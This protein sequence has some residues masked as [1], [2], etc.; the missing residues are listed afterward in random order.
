MEK[1]IVLC[2]VSHSGKTTYAN[3]INKKNKYVIINSDEIRIKL[4]GDRTIK[5]DENK[6]W[7]I[8]EK[9]KNNAIKNHKNIILDAC[10]LSSQARWHAK[11]NING[12][13]VE[14]VVLNP[15]LKELKS[16]WEKENRR[17]D[18]EIIKD[19]YNNFTVSKNKLRLEGYEN[20]KI[21][22]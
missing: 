4:H 19:M 3:K 13:V 12:Y 22:D 17:I 9:K 10:H 20:V 16:R 2:G 6:V 18:W 14:I 7:E 15:N 11:K 1:L 8:F 5:N 21:I